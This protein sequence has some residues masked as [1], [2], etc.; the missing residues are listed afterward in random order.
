MKRVSWIA[1]DAL[2]PCDSGRSST[3]NMTGSVYASA[4]SR[5]VALMWPCSATVARFW[6]SHLSQLASPFPGQRI[7]HHSTPV[8][9]CPSR[10]STASAAAARSSLSSRRRRS[11]SSRWRLW[12]SPSTSSSSTRSTTCTSHVRAM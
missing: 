7:S 4:L 11:R 8:Y 3:A 5:G 10:E 12:A 9:L 2:D 6:P 1:I